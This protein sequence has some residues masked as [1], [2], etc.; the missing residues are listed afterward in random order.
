MQLFKNVNRVGG[1]ELLESTATYNSTAHYNHNAVSSPLMDASAGSLFVAAAVGSS[2]T[3]FCASSSRMPAF[4]AACLATF[5]AF[6]KAFLV[7]AS[8]F[9]RAFLVANSALLR[10][11]LS[12]VLSSEDDSAAPSEEASAHSAAAASASS[13]SFCS[14]FIFLASIM[15]AN[16][17]WELF[18]FARR[19]TI[20]CWTSFL[21]AMFVVVVSSSDARSSTCFC[22]T[23]KTTSPGTV[24]RSVLSE[25]V[26]AAPTEVSSLGA[27]PD[28]RKTLAFVLERM[29]VIEPYSTWTSGLSFEANPTRLARMSRFWFGDASS[30]LPTADFRPSCRSSTKAS[31]A[32]EV[33]VSGF[34]AFSTPVVMLCKVN[35]LR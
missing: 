25:P 34:L 8:A 28:L 3:S 29:S 2:G 14:F 20:R 1:N 11:F 24:A 6:S 26:E 22:M 5:S 32:S 13:A 12:L 21:L 15:A 27:P 31:K 33:Y 35:C 4:R 10:R 23:S 17:S 7:A 19:G 18:N 9:V 30:S 16:L